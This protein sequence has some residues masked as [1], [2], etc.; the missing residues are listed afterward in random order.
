MKPFAPLVAAALAASLVAQSPLTTIFAGPNGL[1]NGGVT[2]INMT[3]L[4]PSITVNRIDVNSNSAAGTEGRVRVWQTTTAPFYSGSESNILNW[5][6]LGEGDVIAAGNDL[7]TTCCF[8][9]PFTLTSAMGPRGYAIEHIGIGPRY[10]NGTGTN[11][12]YINTEINLFAGVAASN[13]NF[14]DPPQLG[15]SI[16]HP[17]T[18]ALAGGGAAR[19][20]NG[21]IHYAVGGSAPVC[22]SSQRFG[23]GCS[24]GFASWFNMTATPARAN[25]KLQG[26]TFLMT[27][28]LNGAYDVATLPAAPLVPYAGHAALGGWA[29][30]ITGATATDDGEVVTPAFSSPFIHPTGVAGSFVVHTNGMISVASNMAYL[31]TLAGGGDDWAPQTTALLNAPNTMWCAW[32]DFDVTTAGTVRYDDNGSQIVITYDAVPN[33]FGVVTDVSTIQWVFDLIGGTVSVTFQA[34]DPVGV[35][36]GNDNYSGNPYLV[37]YSPGGANVRPQY[38]VDPALLSVQYGSVA[39]V[40][41]TILSSTPRPVFGSVIAYNVNNLNAGIPIGFLYFSATNPFELTGGLLLSFI[42]VGRPGCLLNFDLANGIGPFSFGAPGNVLNLD[43]NTVT[44]SM[45]GLDFWGQAIVIDLLAPDLFAG[46]TSSNALHQRIE[47][48]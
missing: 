46:L 15:G 24:G 5:Q 47:A 21:S 45:L 2:F 18:A 27:P 34:V 37:G 3:V 32:H 38:E 12:T 48:N 11:Q 25:P 39:E 14:S 26:K 7:P 8:R 36:P 35:G 40:P 13:S 31:D 1:A 42:G 6:I 17:F 23:L 44:P 28:N 43:T 20:F 29:T 22:S 33:A 19:V 41:H 10:T 4:V 16:S 9:T 30:T